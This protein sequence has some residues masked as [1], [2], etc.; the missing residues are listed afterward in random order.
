MP[1]DPP[2]KSQ[3]QDSDYD[4]A[5]K[6]ALRLH[7]REF[8]EKYFP[9]EHAAIDWS[10]PP[11]WLDKELSLVLGQAGQRNREVDIVAKV[12]LVSG[13]EQWI[14]L[15]V[16]VQTSYEP[17][18]AARLA[19]YNAGLVWSL[20]EQVVTL[21]VL[22][23]LRRN[24]RPAEYLFKVG[25]FESQ[26]RFP[27]CKLLDHLSN[28]WQLVHSLPVLLARAQIEALRTAADPD[29]RFRAK[30]TLLRGLYDL[31]YN[32]QQVRDI[33]V[34]VDWMMHLRPDLE[35]RL[36]DELIRLEDSLQMP[37]V[38]SIERIAE[39]RGEA[40]GEVRG[41]TR[42][43]LTQLEKVCGGVPERRQEQIRGLTSLRLEQLAEA[44]LGF[45][46]LAD[47]ENWLDQNDQPA[48][49]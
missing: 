1:S 9:V 29:G 24:W 38:T 14:L 48:S 21:V 3:Q 8:I 36:G 22:A 37:Y 27:V 23:D 6:E 26:M 43:V 25:G 42:V 16:E 20:Q 41:E 7:L 12:R 17:N 2:A 45:Q 5:W 47:L 31:G 32:A 46:S 33:F 49:R 10:Y 44:L 13:E 34:L 18:F 40:R 11:Q 39:A 15:H 35:Q 28:D 30:W 4:G 19:R